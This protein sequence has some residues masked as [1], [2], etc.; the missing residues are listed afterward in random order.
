MASLGG[1]FA[2]LKSMVA[3]DGLPWNQRPLVEKKGDPSNWRTPDVASA[4]ATGAS[5]GLFLQDTLCK[6]KIPHQLSTWLGAQQRNDT[7]ATFGYETDDDNDDEIQKLPGT[8]F[9]FV[10]PCIKIR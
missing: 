3:V 7:T 10:H 4:G 9:S 8:P 6:K 5:V 2:R 1:N